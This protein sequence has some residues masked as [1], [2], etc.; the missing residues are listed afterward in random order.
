MFYLIMN[1]FPY[2]GFMALHL[3]NGALKLD[4]GYGK[5]QLPYVAANIGPYAGI[6]ASSF[7]LGRIPTA[8]AWGRFADVYGRKFA[9]CASTLAL[10]A[11][12]LLFGLAPTFATAVAVRFCAGFLNGTV[13]VARTA[14]SEIAMGDPK[15]ETRGVAMFSSMSGF[16]MLVGP[17]IGGL[18]SD[19]IKQYP[20]FF[21]N[22]ETDDDGILDDGVR[23]LFWR[24]LL[25]DYP[26]L[27]PNLIG[28]VVA[29]LSLI[30]IV[31]CFEE[32]LPDDQRRDWKLIP[33]DIGSWIA[34]RTIGTIWVQKQRTDHT[35]MKP[36]NH[37]EMR[38][39]TPHLNDDENPRILS[40]LRGSTPA[41]AIIDERTPLVQLSNNFTP[42]NFSDGQDDVK[43]TKSRASEERETGTT[44]S[45]LVA[46]FLDTNTNVRYF[47]YS[48]WAFA[49][50][51]LASLEAFPL[52]AMTSIDKGGLGLDEISIGMVQTVS[53][54]F[55]IVGQYATFTV[56]M[57]KLGWRKM[58]PISLL[59]RSLLLL[60]IP[61]GLYVSPSKGIDCSSNTEIDIDN[62][63]TNIN[64]IGSNSYHSKNW[65]QF[66]YFGFVIGVIGILGSNFMGCATIGVNACIKD[67]SQRASMN[68]LQSM[69]ASIGR[70]VGPIFSGYLVASTMTSGVISAKLSAWVVY[71]V[72]V[73][74][75]LIT[76][77]ISRIIPDNSRDDSKNDST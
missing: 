43:H 50:S 51:S 19:P 31:L 45:T 53:A 40:P 39:N 64:D 26:F 60:L 34:S 44:S 41:A 75:E 72:L 71:G 25:E 1:V 29:L 18:L 30:N 13:V 74:F 65:L 12:N 14:I 76:Y 77:F 4:D 54:C 49:F 20:E 6:L 67:A 9:L 70:G 7:R 3:K 62:N 47:F 2:S 36:N 37:D 22:V 28:S 11:G 17:A 46:T 5:D 24:T 56:A 55:F 58:I 48:M 73:V 33:M 68:G 27:L 15:L 10:V 52:F 21:Y 35:T 23:L 57:K 16:G 42:T 66:V 59:G 8:I 69:V 61:L 32:T 38:Q 63:I